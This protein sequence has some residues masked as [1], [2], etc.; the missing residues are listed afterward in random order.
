MRFLFPKRSNP[1]VPADFNLGQ[2]HAFELAE[3]DRGILYSQTPEEESSIRLE[4]GC[5][6]RRRWMTL[7]RQR[8]PTRQALNFGVSLI[9]CSLEY[10]FVEQHLCCMFGK[11][12]L[13]LT[14]AIIASVYAAPWISWPLV[15]FYAGLG[16]GG[17]ITGHIP[18]RTHAKSLIAGKTLG[19]HAIYLG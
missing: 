10:Q 13:V 5:L 9:G 16:I 8:A 12:F 11:L 17:V 6:S 19:L 14:L 4:G 7:F 15:G 2:P 1:S 18:L 3:P